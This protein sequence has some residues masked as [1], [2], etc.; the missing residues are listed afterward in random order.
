MFALTSGK[1][2]WFECKFQV[3][4]ADQNDLF[5]G[6]ADTDTDVV[7]SLPNDHIGF[8][9]PGDATIDIT[10]EKDN[11]NTTYTINRTVADISGYTKWLIAGFHYD[12]GTNVYTYINT[13]DAATVMGA[14]TQIVAGVGTVVIP[15]DEVM[16]PTI[17]FSTEDTGKDYMQ[18]DYIKVVAER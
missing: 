18:I 13:N 1:E 16:T 9:L 5:I 12:G 11:S 10:V 7:G 17:S 8:V 3:E 15:N 2:L 4:D 14:S 6:L